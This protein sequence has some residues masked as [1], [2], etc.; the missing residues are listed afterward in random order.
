ME[1]YLESD[2]DIFLKTHMDSG[3]RINQQIRVPK[4]RF[5]LLLLSILLLLL[6]SYQSSSFLIHST[7]ILY[8]K[9]NSFTISK[10]WLP[11][12]YIIGIF[13][14]Y[15][16]L[17]CNNLVFDGALKNNTS[18]NPEYSTLNKQHETLETFAFFL[19]R[20]WSPCLL[21]SN[22]CFILQFSMSF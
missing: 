10:L 2:N 21:V 9:L 14:F 16:C 20:K 4:F 5:L 11:N 8:S 22:I 15:N 17:L 18:S 7:K 13:Y 6:A 19:I 3:I 1:S 12:L